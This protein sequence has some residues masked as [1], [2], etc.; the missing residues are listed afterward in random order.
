MTFLKELILIKEVYQKSEIFVTIG[1]F[2][3]NG[4]SING[5]SATVVTTY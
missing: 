2:Y 4:L 1:I 5:M 3:I